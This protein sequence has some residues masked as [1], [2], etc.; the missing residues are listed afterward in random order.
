M[1]CLS[2]LVLLISSVSGATTAPIISV[3]ILMGLQIKSMRPCAF[4]A[5]ILYVL[6]VGSLLSEDQGVGGGLFS[7]LRLSPAEIETNLLLRAKYD[8][9]LRLCRLNSSFYF[10]PTDSFGNF[11][12]AFMRY[13]MEPFYGKIYHE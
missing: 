6:M 8:G 10:A 3:I 4:C 5:V 2:S 13:L 9:P 1:E 7:S 11:L 12:R